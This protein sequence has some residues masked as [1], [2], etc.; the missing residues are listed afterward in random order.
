MVPGASSPARA[1]ASP[2]AT[3]SWMPWSKPSEP[4]ATSA[5]YSPRLWP[6][7][8]AGVRPMRST[9]SRTTRLSTVVASWAFSVWV[10]SSIG[11]RRSRWARSRSAAAE[12]S[13][14]TSH[15]GWSTH[16]SPI[17]ARWDPCPGK[18]KTNTCPTA[19]ID[20]GL[21]NPQCGM[22]ARH[23]VASAVQHRT[24]GA[25]SARAEAA[26]CWLPGG[27]P[28]RRAV[29]PRTPKC[30]SGLAGRLFRLAAPDVIPPW[31]SR[32]R[33]REVV[34]CA[35]QPVP[36]P[37]EDV[38]GAQVFRPGESQA[39]GAMPS[40]PSAGRGGKGPR[41]PG[42]LLVAG[43]DRG[44]HHRDGGLPDRKD[45]SLHGF[46]PAADPMPVSALPAPA[47]AAPS[48]ADH[49]DDRAPCA[50]RVPGVVDGAS[51][52][53]SQRRRSADGGADDDDRHEPSG[54]TVDAGRVG[55][56]GRFR[57]RLR[58]AA[59]HRRR[60]PERGSAPSMTS[61][62]GPPWTTASGSSSRRPKVAT[63]RASSASK[64]V[65]TTC[66]C[67]AGTLKLTVRTSRRVL[68]V[69]RGP[70]LRHRNTRAE[71]SRPTKRF[72]QTD[73]VFEIRAKISDANA[74]RACKVP[75]GSIRHSRR[76]A[77]GRRRARST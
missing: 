60:R 54:C 49:L 70:A 6:A 23:G 44:G 75:S 5:V 62:T 13:S 41:R 65:P 24:T 4:L 11:A 34:F 15:E 28:V 52:V 56:S 18:V 36:Q 9:A 26:Q 38:V 7:Q 30:L 55:C 47:A 2:R 25:T 68:P 12:A 14:T 76:T 45:V 71:W 27:N 69:P 67:R 22:P 57:R 3:T 31:R 39:E 48:M 21:R 58:R 51:V 66:P 1:M 37:S 64:T 61:S 35:P 32:G 8:A 74:Y 59:R 40:G 46:W 63:T 77:R 16:G 10:S 17:P 43:A 53:T 42:S 73:G 50:V 33:P 19:P 20:G 72:T 29:R